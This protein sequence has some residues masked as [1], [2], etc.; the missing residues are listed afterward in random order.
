[1]ATVN[2]FIEQNK[3]IPKY[4]IYIRYDHKSKK[5]LISTQIKASKSEI[6]WITDGRGRNKIA[7]KDPLNRKFTG[8]HSHN[9]ILNNLMTQA[10]EAKADARNK[11]DQ[12]PANFIEI[13]KKRIGNEEVKTILEAIDFIVKKHTVLL[14]GNSLKNY[15]NN[16]RKH[17]TEFN[18]AKGKEH[19][20]MDLDKNFELE[21][22][23]YLRNSGSSNNTIDNQIKYLKSLCRKLEDLGIDFNKKVLQFERR[24][25]TPSKIYLSNK[26]LENLEEAT[27]LH[28]PALQKQKDIFVF[29]CFTGLRV[30][31]LKKINRDTIN[32]ENQ[33]VMKA[34]KTGEHIRIPLMN[35]ALAILD[36]YDYQ[37]PFIS[38]QKYNAAIKR[39]MKELKFDRI[40]FEKNEP[41]H[42]LCT[43]HTARKTFISYALNNLTLSV[44][45]VSE[46]TGTTPETIL[47]NYAGSNIEDIAKKMRNRKDEGK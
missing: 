44:S 5:K 46:I 25:E 22:R 23:E 32:D 11:G 28:L 45:E 24:E 14:K 3:D 47:K 35:E 42:Q 8:Y 17:I 36:K 12:S 10:I 4:T 7:S 19:S 27:L 6:N 20:L 39:F 34:T 26:E 41:L 33:I 13:Y 37:L 43:S 15:N 40:I 38:D 30:S 2:F 1:M 29:Q 21:F 9:E 16:L 31:D 18:K